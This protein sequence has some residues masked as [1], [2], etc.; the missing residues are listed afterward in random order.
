MSKK[1]Y[2]KVIN[3]DR[4]SYSAMFD[5]TLYGIVTYEKDKWTTPIIKKSKLMVFTEKSVAEE[6]CNVS[7][8]VVKCYIKRAKEQPNWVLAWD[9]LSKESIENF[10]ENVNDYCP[11]K[12]IIDY[13]SLRITP[14]NTVFADSVYCLE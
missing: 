2:Y 3:K 1:I 12:E 11:E 14:K 6:W 5:L 13:C 8:I 10:W 7:Q 9:K 4:T